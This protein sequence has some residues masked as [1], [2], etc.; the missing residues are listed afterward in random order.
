MCR[1]TVNVILVHTHVQVSP[2]AV[3]LQCAMP[4]ENRTP[5]TAPKPVHKQHQILSPRNSGPVAELVSSQAGSYRTHHGRHM[6]S[7]TRSCWVRRRLHWL[8][9][10]RL[11]LIWETPNRLQRAFAHIRA[12]ETAYGSNSMLRR[13]GYRHSNGECDVSP[14]RINQAFR[15]AARCAVRLVDDAHAIVCRW[16]SSESSK[17][18]VC[19]HSRG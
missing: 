19:R 18:I 6:D 13:S 11:P 8:P 12:G 3:S 5:S 14:C 2:L 10:S 1:F 4:S 16:Y 9:P 7:W 15:Y 17:L